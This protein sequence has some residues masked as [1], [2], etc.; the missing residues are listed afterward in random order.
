MG[1]EANTDILLDSNF[2]D[3]VENGDFA[4]GEGT[5]DDCQVILGLTTGA[6]KSDPI[7]APNLIQMI[8]SNKGPSEVIQ[9]IKL[10]LNRDSKFPKSIELKNGAVDIKL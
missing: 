4:I 7:L 5:Q 8:N 10:N 6:L 2:E 1:T 3:K 9:K